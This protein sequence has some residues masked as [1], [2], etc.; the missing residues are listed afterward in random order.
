MHDAQR[1]SSL[2]FCRLHAQLHDRLPGLVRRVDRVHVGLHGRGVQG[3]RPVLPGHS[4]HRKSG[5]KYQT[6]IFCN[7]GSL[8]DSL[9][10]AKHENDLTSC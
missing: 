5:R 6:L 2:E 1:T 7:L 3:L 10:M 4:R 8:L 9:K